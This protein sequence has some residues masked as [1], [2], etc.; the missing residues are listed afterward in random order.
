[1]ERQLGLLYVNV[2]VSC[3]T[4]VR[5]AASCKLQAASCKL[6]VISFICGRESQYLDCNEYCPTH[7]YK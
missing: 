7:I 5:Q 2:K 6:Q 1:M 4:L 3:W